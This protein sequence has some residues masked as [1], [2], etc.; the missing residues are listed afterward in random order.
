MYGPLFEQT[1]RKITGE[2]LAAKGIDLASKKA[3]EE[4]ISVARWAIMRLQHKGYKI[5]TADEVWDELETMGYGKSSC[6]SL[7]AIGG[8]F[9]SAN[10]IG[11]I[12]KA[13]MAPQKSKHVDSHARLQTVWEFTTQHEG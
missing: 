12:R 10:H 3:G 6:Y 11:L 4:F 7:N 9:R 8:V 2:E 5:F 13:N 1:S